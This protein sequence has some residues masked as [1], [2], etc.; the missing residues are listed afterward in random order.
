MRW[1]IIE[2][3]KNFLTLNLRASYTSFCFIFR[4]FKDQ[5]PGGNGQ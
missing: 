3:A 5:K 1:A 2:I 4:G